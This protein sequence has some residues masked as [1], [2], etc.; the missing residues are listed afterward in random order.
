MK[1][2]TSP[3][4]LLL[5]SLWSGPA[6]ADELKPDNTYGVIVG[7][8]KWQ[9]PALGSFS[10]RHRK[11]QELRNLLVQRGVPAKNIALLL[12]EQATLA[13]IRSALRTVASAARP[14]STFLFYYAG[15]GS[16]RGKDVSFCNYDCGS[17]DPKKPALALSEVGAILKKHFKGGRVL[18]MA[19]CC[20]SG[21]LK[22]VA[23]E[24]EKAGIKAASV[25]SAEASNLS[26]GNWTFTQAV[27]DSL[28]GE[29]LVDVN[30]D[31]VITLGELVGE[32]S[33][34]MKYREQQM[35]G[36]SHHGVGPDFRLGPTDRSRKLTT[37]PK[38]GLRPGSYVNAPDNGKHRPARIV[39]WGGGKYAV[40]FYDYSDKRVVHLP[41]D[42]LAPIH[43]KTYKV[44][45]ELQVLWQGQAYRAK[46]VKVAGD[47]HFITYPGYGHEWD[48][49]I[50][51]NRV[52]EGAR[53]K[54]I[55][56]VEWKGVWYPAVVLETKGG[57][58]R[59]HYEGFDSSWDEWVGKERIRFPKKP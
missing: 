4:T 31:G 20:H 24:L 30:G 2:R 25:T 32:V 5:L 49:W 8:L 27:L 59:I 3:L 13:N 15:H 26:C 45:Q 18:L 12:D 22:T 50:L 33:A 10:A 16:L 53:G 7:V 17:K 42:Q 11:D 14:G 19:D 46:V 54:Q 37:A 47:F 43:F 35:F 55:V 41:G 34:G 21:G 39:G 48:E 36:H 56:R 6:V 58:Y 40:E 1:S 38:G 28:R 57:K 51:S 52:V 29:P 9:S 44:G 23:A